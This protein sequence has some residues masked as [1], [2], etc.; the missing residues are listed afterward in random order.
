MPKYHQIKSKS[1]PLSF[2]TEDKKCSVISISHCSASGNLHALPFASWETLLKIIKV[3]YQV[4][5][6]RYEE[7]SAEIYVLLPIAG[8][9]FLYEL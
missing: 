4:T 5:S 8:T 9:L 6:D 7:R 3:H 1:S 2:G